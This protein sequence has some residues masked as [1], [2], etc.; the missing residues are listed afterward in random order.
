MVQHAANIAS[1]G[2][3]I[4]TDTSTD[5]GT[6]ANGMASG[7]P[8]AATVSVAAPRCPLGRRKPDHIASTSTSTSTS[9]T[10]HRGATSPG[11]PTGLGGC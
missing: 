1:H 3:T 9:T 2:P 7:T 5:T 6:A 10:G 8:W 4:A 11:A